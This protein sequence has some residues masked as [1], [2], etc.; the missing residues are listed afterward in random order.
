MFDVGRLELSINRM[1][2]LERTC[3]FST[4]DNPTLSSSS[5]S[6]THSK[7]VCVCVCGDKRPLNWQINSYTFLS[8]MLYSAANIAMK[9][10]SV[11]RLKLMSIVQCM[12][13]CAVRGYFLVIS[14]RINFHRNKIKTKKSLHINDSLV[15]RLPLIPCIVIFYR[16][17]KRNCH[18]N[19]IKLLTIRLTL[20]GEFTAEASECVFIAIFGCN[21]LAVQL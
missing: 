13:V 7:D 2:Y 11:I 3:H 15:L 17:N 9:L 12:Y 21:R 8:S 16:Q 6:I 10:S 18:F 20:R 4:V 14:I 19:S 5:M 1:N